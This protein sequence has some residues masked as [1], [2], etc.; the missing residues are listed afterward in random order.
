[1]I[2]QNIPLSRR[3]IMDYSTYRYDEICQRL[4]QA[5][6]YPLDVMVTGVT[7]AGKSSTLNALFRKNVAKV[8][9]GVDPETM[10]IDSYAM[11]ERIRLWDTPGLGDGVQ[12]DRMHARKIVD[13]LTHT[14]QHKDGK[15]GFVDLALV[16]LDGGT[17]EM[18]TTYDLLNN[19][20]L[21]H[22]PAERVLIVINQADVAMKGRHWHNAQPDSE[23][24][25]FLE[26][27]AMSVQHRVQEATGLHIRKPICYSAEQH[28]NIR[29]FFDFIIEHLPSERRSLTGC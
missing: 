11:N 6:F 13:L 12:Q 14:Y 20:V 3:N 27:K 21:Q 7:G 5:R 1:M 4:N 10:E 26:E 29:T 22:L 17:R 25:G 18:G 19:V 24:L 28:Y 9:T 2:P 23:L 15:F 8:G 16:V